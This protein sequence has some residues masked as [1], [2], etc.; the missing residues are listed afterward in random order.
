MQTA[1]VIDPANT[2]FFDTAF[3]PLDGASVASVFA[4]AFSFVVAFF[5]IGRGVGLV[6][7]LIRKG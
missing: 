6:L 5:V 2:D 3:E 1:Y 7:G 4:L